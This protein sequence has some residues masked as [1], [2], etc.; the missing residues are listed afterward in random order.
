MALRICRPFK[1]S[2]LH[3]SRTKRRS[4]SCSARDQ[5]L[6]ALDRLDFAGLPEGQQLELLRARQAVLGREV[7]D[8]DIP[9]GDT[10]RL[11]QAR[12]AQG[13]VNAGLKGL[14]EGADAVGGEE[15]DAREVVE[16]AEE[17]GDQGVA[18]EGGGGQVAVLEEDV[19]FVEQQDGAPGDGVV[20]DLLEAG[21]ELLRVGADVAA[22]DL[23]EGFLEGVGDALRGE[24]FAGA[25]GAVE[26]GDETVAF[27]DD[28]VVQWD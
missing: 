5:L 17:D 7:V 19:G 25:G 26:E 6:E 4:S 3:F 16:G 15:Q 9:H 14:I 27:A 28:E 12:Q 21:L 24:G 18:L 20:E 23:V 10:A 13:N 2:R 11:V 1:R 8:E 22:G